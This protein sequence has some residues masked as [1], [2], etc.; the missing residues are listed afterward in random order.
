MGYIVSSRLYFKTYLKKINQTKNQNK[1]KVTKRK[2]KNKNSHRKKKGGSENSSV[3]KYL[4]YRHEDLSSDPQ[5]LCKKLA[6]AANTCNHCDVKAETGGSPGFRANWL[7]ELVSSRFAQRLG[8]E[9]SGRMTGE[10]T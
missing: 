10:D 6:V 2:I 5:H 3:V 4:L 7:A 8:L 1:V 9:N